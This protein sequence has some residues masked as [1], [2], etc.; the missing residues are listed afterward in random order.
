MA[1]EQALRSSAVLLA[2]T[3]FIG[4]LF[5]RSI[6]VWLA[7]VTLAALLYAIIELVGWPVRPLK[8]QPISPL[9]WNALLIG[10]FTMFVLDLTTISKELLPAGIHFLAVLLIVKLVTLR[11]RRDYRHLYSIS[12]MSVV[13]SAALTADLW[14][15]AVFL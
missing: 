15:V 11:D 3:G 10:A 5:A 4:L 2:A 12:L 14:Y 6:P 8:G 13:A 7:A 1:F 9:A